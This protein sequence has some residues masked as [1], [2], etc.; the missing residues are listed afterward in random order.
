MHQSK[1]EVNFNHS[2]NWWIAMHNLWLWSNQPYVHLW[3]NASILCTSSVH[4]AAWDTISTLLAHANAL[5]I[6]S[7]L[8]YCR[9]GSMN[10]LSRNGIKA[11][12]KKDIVRNSVQKHD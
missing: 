11:K 12:N 4:K 8:K 3:W 7:I 9:P 2:N 5:I 1:D 6:N 10:K